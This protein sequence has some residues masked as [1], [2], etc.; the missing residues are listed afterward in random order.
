MVTDLLD[1]KKSNLDIKEFEKKLVIE[2]LTEATVLSSERF[3]SLIKQSDKLSKIL[4]DNRSVLCNESTS[5]FTS[6]IY[7]LSLDYSKKSDKKQS[8][9]LQIYIV[10]FPNSDTLNLNR[11]KYYIKISIICFLTSIINSFFV[12]LIKIQTLMRQLM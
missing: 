6:T 4:L 8:T 7:K 10:D 9:N 12:V 11:Q 5:K 3:I 2:H 1:S